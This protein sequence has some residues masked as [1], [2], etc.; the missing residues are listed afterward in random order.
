EKTVKVNYNI[1]KKARSIR[2]KLNIPLKE[3]LN[4]ARKIKEK[5]Q[6]KAV[7]KFKQNINE[8]FN[9]K[10]K[11]VIKTDVKEKNVI[12]ADI[13]KSLNLDNH[14]D[15]KITIQEK[16]SLQKA[17]EILYSGSLDMTTY[18]RLRYYIRKSKLLETKPVKLIQLNEQELKKQ[19]KQE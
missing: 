4:K 14:K 15:Y 8:I 17:Y 1:L 2:K 3:A 19:I 16:F 13:S 12:K 11:N 9:K 5:L 10:V 7:K 18:N 6:T